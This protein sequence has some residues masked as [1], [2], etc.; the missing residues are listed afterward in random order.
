MYEI[1]TK[2]G[3]SYRG[4]VIAL[5]IAHSH[6]DI[7]PD[8]VEAIEI[9]VQIHNIPMGTLTTGVLMLAKE[10]GSS[11]SEVQELTLGG[12]KIYKIKLLVSLQKSLKDK[13]IVRHPVIGRF[14]PCFVYEKLQ[15][16]CL[17]C[18]LIGHEIANYYDRQRLTILKREKSYN[19]RPKME[20]IMELKINP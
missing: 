9:W 11:Q 3:W 14:E 8:F 16:V 4:D 2:G 1:L 17:F 19:Q 7:R 20:G 10:V 5:R 13:I 6:S 18:S 12:K 15:R